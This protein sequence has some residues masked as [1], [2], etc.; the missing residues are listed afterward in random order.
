M[1]IFVLGTICFTSIDVIRCRLRA[2]YSSW[3]LLVAL[4]LNIG[5]YFMYL[6]L[7]LTLALL[8]V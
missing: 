2:S 5:Y 8:F 1:L 6:V 4:E 7:Y 3:A